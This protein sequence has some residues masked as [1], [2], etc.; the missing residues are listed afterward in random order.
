[1]AASLGKIPTTLVRRLISP[2]RRSS[3][4][5]DHSFRQWAWGRRR[6]QAGPRRHPE[7]GARVGELALEHA[8]DLVELAADVGGVSVIEP[9]CPGPTRPH[10][11]VT[12]RRDTAKPTRPAL[13]PPIVDR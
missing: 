6:R 12:Q 7:H 13:R 11:Y 4:F 2:L 1:M 10:G 5:V 8:G 3:G 9:A